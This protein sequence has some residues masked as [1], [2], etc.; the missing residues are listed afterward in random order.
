[1]HTIENAFNTQEGYYAKVNTDS[2]TVTILSKQN[3]TA[4]ELI[5]ALSNVGYVSREL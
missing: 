3:H 2:N 4:G 1:M 5:Q